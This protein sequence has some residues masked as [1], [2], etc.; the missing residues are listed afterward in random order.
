MSAAHVRFIPS[1]SLAESVSIIARYR[2]FIHLLSVG[3]NSRL[4]IPLLDNPH[5]WCLISSTV[6]SSLELC[7]LDISNAFGANALRNQQGQSVKRN[8]KNAYT[9]GY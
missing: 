7:V 1:L 5:I 2:S 3:V 8:M 9:P 4:L 6:S